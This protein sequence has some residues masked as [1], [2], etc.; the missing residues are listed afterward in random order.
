MKEKLISMGFVNTKESIYKF[1][2]VDLDIRFNLTRNK[3]AMIHDG[4]LEMIES[5]DDLLEIMDY[6]L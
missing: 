5:Y 1:E 4:E 2:D 3:G 6:I